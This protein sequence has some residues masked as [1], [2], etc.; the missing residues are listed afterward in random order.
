MHQRHTFLAEYF[1]GKFSSP[2]LV[3]NVWKGKEEASD[4]LVPPVPLMFSEGNYNRYTYILMHTT[5]EEFSVMLLRDMA[6]RRSDLYGHK[7]WRI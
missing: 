4:R 7:N 2:A 3:V 6:L 1:D 5:S